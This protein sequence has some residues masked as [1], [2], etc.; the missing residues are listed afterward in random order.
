MPAFGFV[1]I[2]PE[3]WERHHPDRKRDF[4]EAMLFACVGSRGETHV[5]THLFY[6]ALR[7]NERAT[8]DIDATY[9]T[10][11]GPDLR[12]VRQ[13]VLPSRQEPGG[14]SKLITGLSCTS[15][16]EVLVSYDDNRV[17]SIDRGDLRTLGMVL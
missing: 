16:G 3:I 10:T 15:K 5:V 2:A 12:V 14:F 8:K 17:L 7:Y 9:V 4:M 11:L 13:A 1:P 6:N